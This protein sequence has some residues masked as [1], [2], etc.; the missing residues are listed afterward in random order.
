MKVGFRGVRMKKTA[1]FDEWPTRSQSCWIVALTNVPSYRISSPVTKNGEQKFFF[2]IELRQE[3]AYHL[4]LNQNFRNSLSKLLCYCSKI[5]GIAK[6]GK[7]VCTKK[8]LHSKDVLANKNEVLHSSMS[9]EV[10]MVDLYYAVQR[11]NAIVIFRRL[12]MV[13]AFWN[14]LHPTSRPTT[15]AAPTT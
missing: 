9:A 1:E 4:H 8:V 7:K 13:Q 3:R 15:L 11:F 10:F 14:A 2:P 12:Q 6:Y 5:E